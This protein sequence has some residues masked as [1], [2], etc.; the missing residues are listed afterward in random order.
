MRALGR[1]IVERGRHAPPNLVLDIELGTRA[2]YFTIADGLHDL[3]SLIDGGLPAGGWSWLASAVRANGF[4]QILGLGKLT[5]Q[6]SGQM[7]YLLTPAIPEP[8][9][10]LLLCFGSLAVL[11]RPLAGLTPTRC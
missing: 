2:F 11:S 1:N 3:G 6:S 10:L 9:T 5:S 4:G 7:A 8:S